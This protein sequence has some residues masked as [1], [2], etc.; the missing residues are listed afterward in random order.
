MECLECTHSAPP[1]C[2]T[3]GGLEGYGTLPPCDTCKARGPVPTINPPPPSPTAPPVSGL[4]TWRGLEL[5]ADSGKLP[6]TDQ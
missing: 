6:E 4:G 5:E 1:R 3:C 2:A